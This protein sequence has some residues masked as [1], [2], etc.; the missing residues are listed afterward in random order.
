MQAHHDNKSA[1]L[2]FFALIRIRHWIKNGFV[3]AP[4]FFVPDLWGEKAAWLSEGLA[5]LAFSFAASAVYILNDWCDREYD[6]LSPSRSTRPLASDRIPN[7]FA[8][9]CAAT[10]T[11]ASLVIGGMLS[12]FALLCL[13]AYLANNIAYSFCLRRY[14][15]LD[16]TSIA[17]G[18]LLRVLMGA[19]AIHVV[20]S[21]FILIC[22]F[23]L[24]LFLAL[25][26]RRDDL[27]Q[28][29]Q[30]P[31]RQALSGYNHQFLNVASIVLLG[32]LT[33]FYLVYVTDGRVAE[34]LGSEH[35]YITAP[36]VILGV[37]RYLQLSHF[38]RKAGSPVALLEG[39]RLLQACIGLWLLSFALLIY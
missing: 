1:L 7:W 27:Y 5:F 36:F 19:A 2:D 3:F 21:P 34:R 26:K 16:V 9:L 30:L 33:T 35:L 28:E 12:L 4:L 14:S 13:A 8:A 24:A 10:L 25:E 31:A 6:K 23:L 32:A 20:P 11:A 37:L 15:L 22:T 29:V 39:D 17:T 38:D 18:F